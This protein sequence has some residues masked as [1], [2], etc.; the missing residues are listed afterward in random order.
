MPARPT[1]SL[2]GLG[3]GLGLVVSRGQRE[4]SKGWNPT[5][6]PTPNPTPDPTPDPTPNKEQ[7]G[8]AGIFWA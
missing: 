4:T 2:L 7:V 1:C 5:P 6:D 8:R 3:L